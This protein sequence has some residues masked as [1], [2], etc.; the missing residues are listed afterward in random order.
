MILSAQKKDYITQTFS[1]EIQPTAMT[2]S[3]TMTTTTPFEC[4]DSITNIWMTKMETY[5]PTIQNKA[6]R[7]HECEIY[8][9]ERVVVLANGTLGVKQLDQLYN[10]ILEED[11]SEELDRLYDMCW[12]A[13][14]E[15]GAM[16]DQ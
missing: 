6:Q 13:I 15:F 7:W 14:E 4:F 9:R 1:Q 5:L 8:E 16:P 2:T 10:R 12:E 3:N 11:Q